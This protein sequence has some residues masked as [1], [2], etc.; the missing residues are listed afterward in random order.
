MKKPIKYAAFGLLLFSLYGHAGSM[1]PFG[2]WGEPPPDDPLSHGG[3]LYDKWWAELRLPEPSS[4]HP[5]YP[6]NGRKQGSV[7]WRCKE[8]HGWDYRGNSG[9]YATGS[10]Y[11][12]IP[13]INAYAGG[14]ASAV[15]QILTNPTHNYQ[16]VLPL[17]ALGLLAGFVTQGQIDMNK[18]IDSKTGDVASANARQGRE[19]FD[20][21][22]ARCHGPDGRDINFSGDPARPEY[23]GTLARSNPWEAL[24]KIRNGHP[25]SAMPMRHGMMGRWRHNEAM[26]PFRSLSIE[27]QVAI[28]AYTRT[29]AEK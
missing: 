23:I 14:D 24:H 13:G 21:N 1:R 16:S 11:T 28:L 10:H 6:Q 15:T 7:T 9:H 12:G 18:Y 8:C 19:L 5:S 17:Q 2:N 26:P 29:L 22:C 20:T 3:R 25:G 4:T 27:E